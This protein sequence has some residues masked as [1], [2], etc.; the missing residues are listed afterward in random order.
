MRSV[1]ESKREIDEA[2]ARKVIYLPN[3]DPPELNRARYRRG[4]IALLDAIDYLNERKEREAKEGNEV[5][6]PN[7]ERDCSLRKLMAH[8]NSDLL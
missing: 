5:N 3:N 6:C 4:L 1:Q 8:P 7:E 2:L